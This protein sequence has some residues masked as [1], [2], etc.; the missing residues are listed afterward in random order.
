[1]VNRDAQD[2][3]IY[4]RE[5]GIICLIR[6]DLVRSYRGPGKGEKYKHYIFPLQITQGYIFTKVAGQGKIGR[7]LAYF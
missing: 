4:S 6:R 7:W 1:M 2:L 3:G 5:P